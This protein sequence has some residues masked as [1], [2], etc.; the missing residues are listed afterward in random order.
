MEKIKHILL[1]TIILSL[2]LSIVISSVGTSD[3]NVSPSSMEED[4]VLLLDAKYSLSI[5][6]GHVFACE[7]K[8]VLVG[9]LEDHTISLMVYAEGWAP[10]CYNNYLIGF[11][12][13]SDL[14]ISFKAL[15]ERPAAL[16]GF[17][18]SNGN[19]WEIIWIREE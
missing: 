14:V 19:V 18:D 15:D 17:R 5:G 4:L 9:E 16:S 7:I 13:Y 11:E 2:V 1:F 10:E 12:N 3:D 8:E 6:Y